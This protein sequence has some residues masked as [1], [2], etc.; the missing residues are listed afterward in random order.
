MAGGLS[1]AELI[2]L[3][4]EGGPF[5]AGT[6][7]KGEEMIELVS[8]LLRHNSHDD[9]VTLMV[10]EAITQEYAGPEGF[11]EAWED[12]ISPYETF[13]VELEEVIRLED[14]L[15][16]TVS[17][18]VTTR[19]DSVAVETPSTAVWWIEDGQIRQAAFYLDRQA[20]LKAA[21]LASPDRPPAD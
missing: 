10:S 14:K 2:E 20:G 12:W 19:Q 6:T 9:Y 18:R 8:E 11:K 7:I 13:E 16:F 3:I 5:S 21:G 1:T 15:V 4:S 17:Q